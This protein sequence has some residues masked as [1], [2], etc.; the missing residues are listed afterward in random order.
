[1]QLKDLGFLVAEEDG[2]KETYVFLQ[3][4]NKETAEYLLEVLSPLAN[5]DVSYD[6]STLKVWMQILP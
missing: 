4:E 2:Y 1:M 3:A 5:V 6:S